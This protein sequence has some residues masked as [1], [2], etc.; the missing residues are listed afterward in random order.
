MNRLNELI[1]G[2]FAFLI[3]FT[4]L[5]TSTIAKPG[6][7][8]YLSL[9][10]TFKQLFGQSVSE[11][12]ETIANKYPPG[13]DFVVK[14][15][16]TGKGLKPDLDH[17]ARYGTTKQFFGNTIFY[18]NVFVSDMGPA[19][20]WPQLRSPNLPYRLNNIYESAPKNQ[21]IV[22]VVYIRLSGSGSREEPSAIKLSI[23]GPT[24]GVIEQG[25]GFNF[26]LNAELN[27]GWKG[28]I[29]PADA[30][31]RVISTVPSYNKD[32]K[33]EQIVP[34]TIN[35]GQFFA[36][37]PGSVT[38]EAKKD[39]VSTTYTFIVSEKEKPKKR[40]YEVIGISLD[41]Q[42]WKQ[43]NRHRIPLVKT[44]EGLLLRGDDWTNGR[45]GKDG[46]SDG[47]SAISRDKFDF[48]NGG[49][50][51]LKFK[52]NG[53]GKYLNMFPRIFSPASYQLATTHHSF[54]KSVVLPENEWLYAHFISKPDKR[55]KTTIC[56]YNYDFDN[57]KPILT[58]TGVMSGTEGHVYLI[59]ADNYLGKAQSIVI[60]D[61][62]VCV[63]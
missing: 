45:V 32:G 33:V 57:G 39:G 21:H 18:D 62:A 8:N 28:N 46:F 58:H 43:D 11:Q 38:I 5:Q 47:N 27:N 60:G 17:M 9:F 12:I 54:M 41:P 16:A 1:L 44:S 61:A 35:A 48:K 3:V 30:F 50:V 7:S 31:W 29:D 14:I 42:Y 51:I 36:Q 6:G 25:A 13:V 24:G 52:I 19:I 23:L 4:L 26:G 15:T 40:N 56:R 20:K 2:F 37:Y 63:K 34:G 53:A 59:F 55:F 49:E 22:D 10:E